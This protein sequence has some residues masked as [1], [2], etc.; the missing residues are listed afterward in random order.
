MN[1]I[2]N[3]YVLNIVLLFVWY[4]ILY[5]DNKSKLSRKCFVIIATLQWVFISGFRHV[6]IGSDTLAYKTIFESVET[7]TI[8]QL[9]DNFIGIIFYGQEGKDP[10]YY[11]FM[12]MFQFFSKNYQVYLVSIAL[13][14]TIPFGYFVYKYS[15]SPLISFIIYSTLFYEF[16]AITGHRQT[17]ATAL[18]TLIGFTLITEK[19]Y[20]IFITVTAIAFTVHKSALIFFPFLFFDHFKP[21]RV[22]LLIGLLVFAFLMVFRTQYALLMQAISGYDYGIYPSAGTYTFTSLMLILYVLM[23][24]KLPDLMRNKSNKPYINALLVSFLLTPLTWIN[25]SAMRVVQ[26][27]SI[28]LVIYIPEFI[29]VFKKKESVVIATIAVGIL[30]ILFIKDVPVYRFFF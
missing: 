30:L 24:W 18:V 2:S 16:F 26:Y 12:K 29:F 20:F 7:Q 4:F 28:F 17:I 25:P 22:R 14:F 6:S 13:I 27:Y 21:T 10:G 1:Y 8:N 9:F 11:I 15:K 3:I 5:Y 23:I 19:K